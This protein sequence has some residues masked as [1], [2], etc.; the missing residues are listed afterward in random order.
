M[1]NWNGIKEEVIHVNVYDEVYTNKEI[2]I[3]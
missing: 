2:K 3:I 1:I